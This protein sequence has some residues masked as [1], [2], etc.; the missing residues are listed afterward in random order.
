MVVYEFSIKR[1]DLPNLE[2]FDILERLAKSFVMNVS[3]GQSQ[4]VNAF[5]S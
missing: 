2:L 1:Y 5:F 4:G 3:K